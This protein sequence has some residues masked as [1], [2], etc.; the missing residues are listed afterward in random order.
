MDSR[1]HNCGEL[2]KKNLNQTVRL[3]GWVNSTR[4]HGKIIF[5]DIRDRFGKTQVVLNQDSLVEKGKTLSNE[6]VISIS[7]TVI[8]RSKDLIND[9]LETG[10]IEIS[11]EELEV[12]NVSSALPMSVHDREASNEEHRLKYRYLELRNAELQRNL[13]MRHKTTQVVRNFLTNQNFI[14]IETPVLTK[15]TPE[16]ARDYLVPS[17]VH[18]GKFYALP[19][20]PQMY[21]QLFM[22]SGLDRYFQIVKCF[23]D[24]DLRSDRQPEFTQIDLEMSFVDEEHVR[25][26]VE[27]LIITVFKEVNNVKMDMPFPTLSYE[28][29][30]NRFGTDKPDLRY[31]IELQNFKPF[32]DQSDFKAFKDADSVNMINV[33]NSEFFSR[34]IIS[35]LDTYAQSLGAK[36][37]AWMKYNDSSFEGGISKFFETKLQSSIASECNIDNNSICFMVADSAE[38]S[39]KV[40]GKIRVKIAEMLNLCDDSIFKPVWIVDFPLFSW[41]KDNERFDSVHHPFVAPKDKDLKI[42]ISD[43]EKAI[44]KG[45]DIVINGYEVAGG[46]IRIH[47]QELQQKIFETMSLTKEDIENKFG[48]FIDA[49]KFGTPPH[50]GIA[51]GLDRLVMLLAGVNNI[52][53]VIAFPKTTSASALMED[54]PNTVSDEQLDDLGIGIK[55]NEKNV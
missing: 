14:E 49:L 33:E 32:S 37:L 55:E 21:K 40:L 10:E 41:D 35:E 42:A 54:S 45:Y 3:F 31:D 4:T 6:D 12:L 11:V 30:L 38:V 1:T 39:L 46:S 47:D 24:E 23:R 17:R 53:D 16:G 18:N 2:T 43:P 26:M 48:F 22:I 8:A 5:I 52:R 27:Q 50:G 36:G 44:S 20:S 29:A 51:F 19:Q 25:D 13:I 28:E 7:G 34:K 9:T 15:S